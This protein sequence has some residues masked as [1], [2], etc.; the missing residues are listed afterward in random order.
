MPEDKMITEQVD[1]RKYRNEPEIKAQ[2][3]NKRRSGLLSMGFGQSWIDSLQESRPTL[4]APEVVRG[5]IDGLSQR[6]FTNPNKM[7]ESLPAILGYAFENIDAKLEGLRQRGFSN[8]H[9]MIES[10]PA[11]LGLAFENI[12]AKLEGLRQRGFTNPHKMIESLPAILGLAFENI[13]A[14]LEG[15]RQR[16]FTNPNKMIESSPA[17]LGLAF[18]NIDAKLEGLRQRGFTNPNKMIE[19][20]PAILGLA[21][22]NIDLR[23]KMFNKLISHYGL[24]FDAIELMEGNYFLFSSKIDKMWTLPRILAEFQLGPNDA[25]SKLIRNI[26]GFNLEDVLVALKNKP[27]GEKIADFMRRVRAIKE[28]KIP[29]AEKRRIIKDELA[30]F[31]KVKRRYLRGYR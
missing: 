20:S 12:D 6:G 1:L 5:H 7:I 24:N 11:I 21:F 15:L 23:L 27:S 31:D 8:P 29:K 9:K 3:I 26:V 28:Q 2:E 14:K 17:I 19:S 13:D 18:E 30:G 4:Y 25:D 10:S 22:E 16:G